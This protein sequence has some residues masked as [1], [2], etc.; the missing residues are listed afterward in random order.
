MRSRTINYRA[1]PLRHTD[2]VA[3]GQIGKH[4]AMMTVTTV[5]RAIA[6]WRTD[7][8]LSIDRKR[9]KISRATVN[10]TLIDM[11][12]ARHRVPARDRNGRQPLI[13]DIGADIAHGMSRTVAAW[14]NIRRARRT[15]MLIAAACGSASGTGREHG[16]CCHNSR[17]R[18]THFTLLFDLI[19]SSLFVGSNLHDVVATNSNPRSS[20]CC[21]A[22]YEGGERISFLMS[23]WPPPGK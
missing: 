23:R 3:R 19:C 17:N 9:R 5:D 18:Q 2:V 11:I 13:G 6:I 4:A 15:A 8:S 22:I 20:S 1:I 7:T 16:Q 12:I 14:R 10:R 21:C